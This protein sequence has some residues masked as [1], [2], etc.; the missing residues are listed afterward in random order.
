MIWAH[1]QKGTINS[2]YTPEMIK[3]EETP[4][5]SHSATPRR[6]GSNMPALTTPRPTAE[7]PQQR[8]TP[9]LKQHVISPARLGHSI[10]I[11]K[12]GFPPEDRAA[13]ARSGSRF[14]LTTT[15]RP[16]RAVKEK[17]RR[18]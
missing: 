18:F 16:G 2:H 15:R 13:T 12:T 14:W 7:C 6:Q 10:H 11:N 9:R 4:V 8:G 3:W 5:A 17:R 1:V